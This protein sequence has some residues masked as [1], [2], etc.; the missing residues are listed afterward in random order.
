MGIVSCKFGCCYFNT[1]R[2]RKY[3]PRH[4]IDVLMS[5][6]PCGSIGPDD[7]NIIFDESKIEMPQNA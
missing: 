2:Q 4:R 1:S 7:T 5:L 3:L 6:T